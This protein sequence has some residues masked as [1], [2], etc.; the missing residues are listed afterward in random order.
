M[1]CYRIADWPEWEAIVATDEGISI[2]LFIA[3]PGLVGRGLGHRM[4]EGYVND[5]A[6]PRFADERVCWITHEAENV[7]ALRCSQ[8]VG[9]RVVRDFVEDGK[10]SLLLSK[11]RPSA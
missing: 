5:V 8:A 10:A 3:E 9:F 2:D 4:L 6:F 7:A 1:Q 11:S